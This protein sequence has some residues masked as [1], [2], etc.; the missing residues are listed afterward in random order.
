MNESYK[1][2]TQVV[3]VEYT[4]VFP[5]RMLFIMFL[6][7]LLGTLSTPLAASSQTSN[8]NVHPCIQQAEAERWIERYTSWLNSSAD[9]K[10]T[11]DA[12]IADDFQYFS[13]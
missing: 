3:D 10:E 1:V 7:G 8:F 4:D 5:A 12:I 6:V 13:G 9:A 2:D 11:G